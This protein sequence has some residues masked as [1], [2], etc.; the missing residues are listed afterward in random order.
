MS[1]N[2]LTVALVL[3]SLYCAVVAVVQGARSR[4]T[5]YA[6]MGAAIFAGLT[7]VA[8]VWPSVA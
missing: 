6:L 5:T 2:P 7:T 1:Q 8:T 4:R 3:L